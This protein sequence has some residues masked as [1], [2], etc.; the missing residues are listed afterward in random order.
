MGLTKTG[1]NSGVVLISSGRNSVSLLYLGPVQE[2]YW[3]L[4][5]D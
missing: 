2:L 3:K 1:L 4:Y 5:F